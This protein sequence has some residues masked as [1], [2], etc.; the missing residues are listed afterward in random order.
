MRK[1]ATDSVTLK[2]VFG[3]IVIVFMFWGIGTVGMDQMEVVAR[4][5]DRPISTREFDRAYTNMLQASPDLQTSDL[6]VDLLRTQVLDQLITAEL[7]GQEAERLGLTVDEDELRQSIAA[8]PAFQVE[9]RFHKETYLQ[10]LQ[11]NNLKPSDFETNQRRHLQ[12]TKLQE[13]IQAGIHVGEEEVRERYRFE[14]ERVNLRYL[15]VPTSAFLDQVTFTEEEAKAHY[16]A[17]KERF[18]E[19]ERVR[20]QY[21]KFDPKTFAAEVEPSD[22]EIQTYYDAHPSEFQRPEEVRARHLLLKV[23]AEASEEQRREVRA[24]A[25]ALLAQAREGAD[26]EA[27]AREHSED[28]TKESGGDLGFFGRGTMTEK[29]EEAAFALEPGAVSEV[30]ETPFGFH[31]IRLEEKRA[32][33]ARP[34]DEVRGEITDKVRTR[35]SREAALARVEEAHEKVID[36]QELAAVASSLNLSVEFPPPF[37]R[38]EA[39]AGLGVSPEMGEAVAQTEAG[40]AGD[41][42]TLESGYVLFRV[43]ER[44]ASYVPSFEQI[45]APVEDDLRR[46]RAAAAAKTRAAELL[47]RLGQGADIETLAAE[48][49]VEVKETGPVGRLG[50]YVPGLGNLPALKDAAFRLSTEN[51]VAPAT[52]D[53]AG[54]T[55]IALLEERLAAEE[56]DFETRKNAL[57]ERI[58]REREGAVFRQFVESLKKQATIEISAAAGGATL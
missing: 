23:A 2:V 19:P 46:K 54:G 24:R 43:D 49:G 47:E 17:E 6:P 8:I 31:I 9:G 44:I 13:L 21:V 4:V 58:R 7:I 39:I 52:Y 26:F 29:F 20:I 22:E 14:S 28:V 50:P 55:I 40:E 16:E 51:A 1:R 57:Q 12:R 48:Q 41:V 45:K 10:T 33:G 53:T 18:R 35:R 56:S 38:S 15:E 37:A 3:A 34:L 36:G 32:A 11:A 42:V 5:N 25:D 27:L 30:V